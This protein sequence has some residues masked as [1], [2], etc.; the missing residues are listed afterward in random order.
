MYWIED[1]TNIRTFCELD[2]PK[3]A[4]AGIACEIT[5]ILLIFSKLMKN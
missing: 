1:A 3:V 5:L 4:N 2:C